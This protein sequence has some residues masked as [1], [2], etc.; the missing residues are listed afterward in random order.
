VRSGLAAAAVFT[1][2]VVGA[3]CEL[4]WTRPKNSP[5]RAVISAA[6]PVR[7]PGRVLHHDG[8]RCSSESD[9]PIT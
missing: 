1:A 7:I 8:G 2:V 5:A 4:S 3:V 9:M 6:T